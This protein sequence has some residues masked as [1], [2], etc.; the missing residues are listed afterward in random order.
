MRQITTDEPR[1]RQASATREWHGM[2]A[3][4]RRCSQ[5]NAIRY[6]SSH[7]LCCAA[8]MVQNGRK[9]S[10]GVARA[11]R[12]I[13]ALY[14]RTLEQRRINHIARMQV[15]VTGNARRY[16]RARERARVQ[17]APRATRRAARMRQQAS[18]RR[19]RRYARYARTGESIVA[20]EPVVWCHVQNARKRDASRRCVTETKGSRV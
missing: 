14:T 8:Y 15:A 9:A 2:R 20:V 6:M 11:A 1:K 12:A 3:K 16:A 7:M 18:A 10:G 5:E 19:A 13:Y 4:W 17:Y